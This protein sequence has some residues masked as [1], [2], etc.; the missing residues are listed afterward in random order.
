VFY[1]EDDL[2][3]QFVNFL[4]FVFFLNWIHAMKPASSIDFLINL[5]KK[6]I[7][8]LQSIKKKERSQP[9]FFNS[10][11]PRQAHLLFVPRKMAIFNLIK[12]AI[13]LKKNLL[14]DIMR[15]TECGVNQ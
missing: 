3:T 2:N 11:L 4:I 14:E 8:F 9:S 5:T 10:D 12:I 13:F 1:L 15:L 6:T 7:T